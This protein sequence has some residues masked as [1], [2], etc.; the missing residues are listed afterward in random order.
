MRN[1][2][3]NIFI[4]LIIFL[5]L[6]LWP[7][8]VLNPYF[9]NKC[10]YSKYKFYKENEQ[11][12]NTIILGSSRLY[13]QINPQVLDN[14]LKN[15]KISTFNLA[16]P[17]TYNPEIYYLYE[18]LLRNLENRYLKYVLLELQTINNISSDN[19]KT[20]RNYYWHN[21]KYLFFVTHYSFASDF[22]LKGK[23]KLINKYVLS[24]TNKFVYGYRSIFANKIKENA[25]VLG[26]NKDGF[27]PLDAQMADIGGNNYL[28]E[29][30]IKFQEDK[31][32]LDKR[33]AKISNLFSRKE[34]DLFI[35]NNHL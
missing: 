19:L 27:Y 26:N 8:L 24:Y 11:K 13:R 15:Y 4:F 10:Y 7:N 29:R 25:L 17:S 12:Y 35:N 16:S 28:R 23:I 6:N 22:S 1:F 30:Y 5:I 2:F 18:N 33:K 14:I 3:I 31:S 34:S 21:L 9:G 20:A 32:S